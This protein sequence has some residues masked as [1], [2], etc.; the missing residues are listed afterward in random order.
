LQNGA[1]I[2]KKEQAGKHSDKMYKF[3][4]NICIFI[5]MKNKQ[6]RHEAI[7]RL[8]NAGRA[9]NQ[10]EL[11]GLLRSEGFE[12]TQATLSRDLHEMKVVKVPDNERGYIYVPASGKLTV[13][14]KKHN[15]I[16]HL[17]DGFRDLHISANLA[18]IRTL[19]G[20]ASSIA[21]VIDNA[22]HAELL[23]TIAGDDTILVVL[24]ENVTKE[25]VKR[26]LEKTLPFIK[27][28]I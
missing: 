8:I 20:Y 17:S 7:S 3:A 19:P 13:P 1:K 11:S 12:C 26:A 27:N 28:K 23:G 21:V 5:H 15:R 14:E 10:E 2:K 6:K 22:Q 18:V 16:S 25:E 9:G 24:K 4:K